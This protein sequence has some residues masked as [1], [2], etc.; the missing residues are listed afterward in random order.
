MTEEI[1]DGA[2][3]APQHPADVALAAWQ[4]LTGKAITSLSLT[5]DNIR[6]RSVFGALVYLLRTEY[7]LSVEVVSEKTSLPA[8]HV[9]LLTVEHNKLRARRE[10]GVAEFLSRLRHACQHPEE[11]PSPAATPSKPRKRSA[12]QAAREREERQRQKKE[13]TRIKA[14]RAAAK[15]AAAE[16]RAQEKS[17]KKAVEAQAKAD[18]L[19]TIVKARAARLAVMQAASRRTEM[20]RRLRTASKK[21][22]LCRL[23]VKAILKR[24]RARLDVASHTL[25][26][27][28]INGDAWRERK[29]EHVPVDKEVAEALIKHAADAFRTHP[30]LVRGLQ[31]DRT[32]A[33]LAARRS[34]IALLTLVP[35]PGT[36]RRDIARFFGVSQATVD[37][38]LEYV[39][40]TLTEPEQHDLKQ[41]W[42][43]LCIHY[44][45]DPSAPLEKK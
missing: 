27:L 31:R 41:C 39:A 43:E 33:A 28:R 36:S 45:V 30:K 37:G 14:E 12:E 5:E 9:R 16:L 19:A 7:K 44:H 26:E 13:R 32:R 29:K 40:H 23:Q 11:G 24:T 15:K 8:T 17:A 34:A 2:P 10:P 20:R 6:N 22:G 38:A 25:V 21:L 4:R 35:T 1:P 3:G 42:D 18:K